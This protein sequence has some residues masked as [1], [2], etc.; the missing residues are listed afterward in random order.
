VRIFDSLTGKKLNVFKGDAN[1]VQ[2]L[3]FS[4]DGKTIAS[5]TIEGDVKLWNL[6]TKKNIKTLKGHLSEITSLEFSPDGQ[7]I[8]TGSFDSTITIW[9]IL[10]GQEIKTFDARSGALWRVHFSPD[11]RAIA[12]VGLKDNKLKVWDFQTDKAPI[13]LPCKSESLC[14]ATD[15]IVFG[16]N[17]QTITYSGDS[18]STTLWDIKTNREIKT[19][20]WQI[21][22]QPFFSPDG[23][24]VASGVAG[25]GD[26]TVVLRDNSTGKILQTFRNKAGKLSPALLRWEHNRGTSSKVSRIGFSSNSKLIAVAS[27]DRTMT[28][29][30]ISN[31]AKLKTFEGLIEWTGNIAFS[32]NSKLIATAG[33]DADNRE[34]EVKLWDIETG[35]LLKTLIQEPVLSDR[36]IGRDIYF[37]PDS[38]T[39]AVDSSDATV[40]LWDISTGQELNIPGLTNSTALNR[41]QLPMQGGKIIAS[42]MPDGRLKRWDSSS[43]KELELLNW[44]KVLT[45][46]VKFSDDRQTIAV[47]N[48]DGKKQIRDIAT[49]KELNSIR[50]D[51]PFASSIR[52]S[53]DGSTIAAATPQGVKVWN[54]STGKEISTLKTDTTR[55][56]GWVIEDLSFSPDGKTIVTIDSINTSGD[57][58]VG[59]QLTL[60]PKTKDLTVVS[61]TEGS[62]AGVAGIRSEDII[63]KIDAQ[64]TK[65]MSVNDAVKLI[66]GQIGSKVVL[67]VRRGSKLLTFPLTRDSI[68]L[69]GENEESKIIKLWNVQT[70]KNIETFKASLNSANDIDFSLDGRTIAFAKTDGSIELRDFST[71]KLITT[72]GRHLKQV[73]RVGFSPDGKMLVSMTVLFSVDELKLWDLTTGQEI[74]TYKD[75]FGDN[76]ESIP[77]SAGVLFSP[78]GKSIFLFSNTLS[79]MKFTRWNLDLE[80]LLKL[81]CDKVWGNPKAKD[82]C[83]SNS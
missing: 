1:W 65:G 75:A 50:L 64:T 54:A 17:N 68:G 27:S 26:N 14:R 29:W 23:K 69:D 53:N 30:D 58:G 82:V 72:L 83:G 35:K 44:Y 21:G 67:T 33:M 41:P 74:R 78:D 66:R 2:V 10:T 43:G 18:Y 25:S 3:R 57:G 32:P 19:I 62:P 24:M 59:L 76:V 40:R 36:G 16:A 42:K 81:G 51:F 73:D 80:D 22:E 63:V 37:T 60:D 11:G 38:K 47:I 79:H 7:M 61:P 55:S 56:N 34:S 52:F 9:N 77:G 46:D 8:A 15:D 6:A 39:I 4:P 48:W 70:G 12:F 28:L 13:A 31:G 45:S 71:G 49:G 20:K 5:G